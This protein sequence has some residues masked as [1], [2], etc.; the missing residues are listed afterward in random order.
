MRKLQH[1]AVV[2]VAV[3]GLSTLGTG[4]GFADGELQGSSH[5]PQVAAWATS[6]S[7]AGATATGGNS[8]SPHAAPQYVAPAPAPQPAPQVYAPPAPQSYPDH[9]K[10]KDVDISQQTRCKSHDLNINILGQV[11]LL[12]GALGNALNGKGHPGKQETRQGT[13]MGCNNYAL[14]K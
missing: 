1:V 12:N 14:S 3:A 5:G 11:G 8:Y 9:H 4:I 7:A 2:V 6:Q 13:S 10:G